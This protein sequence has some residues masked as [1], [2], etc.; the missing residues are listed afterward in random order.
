MHADSNHEMKKTRMPRCVQAGR[1]L[2][3][4]TTP[5]SLKYFPSGSHSLVVSLHCVD[6]HGFRFTTSSHCPL[7]HLGQC[8]PHLWAYFHLSVAFRVS[9]LSYSL[10]YPLLGYTIPHI[11]HSEILSTTEKTSMVVTIAIR[12]FQPLIE[13]FRSNCGR[14]SFHDVADH[15]LVHLHVSLVHLLIGPYT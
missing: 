13:P 4:L 5:L 9:S 10:D 3:L 15:P 2:V 6:R 11:Y 1:P 8:P 14:N 12:L 7:F